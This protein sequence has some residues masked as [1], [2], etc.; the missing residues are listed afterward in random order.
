MGIAERN[1]F[2]HQIIRQIG[3]GGES[4]PS[5]LTHLLTPGLDRRNHVAK[6][7]QTADDGIHRIK[8]RFLVLLIV[9]VI[10]Q[11]LALHQGQQ[12]DQMPIDPP[13]L[14]A[15]QFRHIRIFLLRHDRGTGAEPIRQI[16]EGKLR[17]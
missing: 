14:A 4:A 16:D 2:T 7:P 9:L 15:H 1:A 5:R 17:R 3:R 8:Q 10:S 13:G 6:R 12:G 11:R